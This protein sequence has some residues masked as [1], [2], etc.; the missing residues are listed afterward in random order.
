MPVRTFHVGTKPEQLAVDVRR[1][2]KVLG[3]QLQRPL[4]SGLGPQV[5]VP[6]VVMNRGAT[7][8]QPQ[9]GKLVERIIPSRRVE[10]IVGQL[11]PA[12]CQEGKLGIMNVVAHDRSLVWRK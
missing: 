12:T 9:R 7:G 3:S 8:V 5:I 10:Q 4:A 1:G 2:G 11:P 6:V